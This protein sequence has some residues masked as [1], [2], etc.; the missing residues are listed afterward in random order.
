MSILECSAEMNLFRPIL[1]R[2]CIYIHTTESDGCLF[3]EL[4]YICIYIQ[5]TTTWDGTTRIL[6]TETTTHSES[7]E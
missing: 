7:R 4:I 3:G 5:K 1:G 6:L 2:V